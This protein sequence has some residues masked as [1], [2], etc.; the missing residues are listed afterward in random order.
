MF[1]STRLLIYLWAGPTTVIGLLLTALALATGGRATVVDGV[2][3]S[4]GGFAAFFLRRCTLLEGGAT[5]MTLG[6]V[7]LGRDQAALDRTRR[8]ERV[9]VRQ[10]ERWGPFFLPAYLIASIVAM[11]RGR[12]PYRDNAFEVQAYA[13]EDDDVAAV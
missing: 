13:I 12:H 6:H 2:L 10:V 4:S 5:A 11:A 3:E 7:V 9:H 8:H 1:S